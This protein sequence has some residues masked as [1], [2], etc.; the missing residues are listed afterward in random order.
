MLVS[1]VAKLIFHL[2][3]SEVISNNES[4]IH[5]S[6]N[7]HISTTDKSLQLNTNKSDF[8]LVWLLKLSFFNHRNYVCSFDQYTQLNFNFINF[9]FWSRRS[10]FRFNPMKVFDEQKIIRD[11]KLLFAE[12]LLIVCIPEQMMV[13]WCED[14]RSWYCIPEPSS[15]N[16]SWS[17]LQLPSQ[18]I[19]WENIK[20]IYTFKNVPMMPSKLLPNYLFLCFNSNQ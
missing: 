9:L 10:L 18:V 20:I 6:S 4:L 11:K 1:E 3:D 8:K 14:V 12:F 5:E 13:C 17:S 2:T 19:I 16:D 7:S 15:D